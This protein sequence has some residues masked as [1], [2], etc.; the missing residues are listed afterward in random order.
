MLRGDGGGCVDG[1]V[2]VRG[3]GAGGCYRWADRE[4]GGWCAG[5]GCVGFGEGLCACGLAV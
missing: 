3:G 2:A 1:E 5:W 4:D